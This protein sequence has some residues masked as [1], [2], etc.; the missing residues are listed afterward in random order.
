MNTIWDSTFL[1]FADLISQRS[2][3][4]D[5]KVGAVIVSAPPERAVLS[6]GYNG[7]ARG[8]DDNIKERY[9]RPEKYY[10][11][12]HAETNA[13]IAAACRGGPPLRGATLYCTTAPCMSCANA[14]CQAGIIEVVIPR[15]RNFHKTEE[16][17]NLRV[18]QLFQEF[19]VILREV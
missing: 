8:I 6:T 19:G 5:T 16:E 13:I 1:G 12:I 7:F 3:D 15:E 4:P 11:M 2:K 18:K 9:E 10:W 14:I 17:N